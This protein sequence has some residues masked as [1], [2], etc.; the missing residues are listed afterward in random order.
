[1][2]E[3]LTA[4]IF[5]VT[6]G[7]GFIGSR[8]VRALRETGTTIRV[9]LGP[10]GAAV[11][12]AP[13]DVEAVFG[14]IGDTAALMPLVEGATTVVHLA[15]PASVAS[16]FQDPLAYA[17]AHVG[18]TAAVVD[19]CARVGVRRLVFVSSSEVYGQPEVNPVQED[20][21]LAPRS[22][23]AAAKVGAEAFIRAGAV[24]AGF[25]AV[26]AR[27]FIVYGPG[28][29]P[30]SLVG[31]LVRQV[32][33]RGPIEVV[34]PRPIRDYC[35]VE[36]VVRA[37]AA[38][39]SAELPEQVRVY[40]IGSGV[41]LSVSEVAKRVLALSGRTCVVRSAGVSD[42]PRGADIIELISDPRRAARE[43]AWQ[44]T[45]DIDTGLA[46]MLRSSMEESR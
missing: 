39:C 24:A 35:F 46:Q 34:D 33:Q 45:T 4:V 40:N 15:G 42:R 10:P 17:H 12:A 3:G 36:D 1:L 2:G 8:V 43:L 38:S 11:I 18:G 28:M 44:A 31:S 26:I 22:P 37:L 29:S 27:L 9:L 41:G 20:A 19:V 5:A 32:R 30:T 23:Y 7:G 13:G 21:P 25:E 14:D 6:G 16:S